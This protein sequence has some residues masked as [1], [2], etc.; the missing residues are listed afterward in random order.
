M[1]KFNAINPLKRSLKFTAIFERNFFWLLQRNIR[2]ITNSESERRFIYRF[3]LLSK[4]LEK[5]KSEYCE[6]IFKQQIILRSSATKV[7]IKISARVSI[8]IRKNWLLTKNREN[9]VIDEG[10]EAISKTSQTFM[11]HVDWKPFFSIKS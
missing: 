8:D 6:S 11:K 1:W 3:S 5:I 7:K 2:E 10:C 9:Y 4:N